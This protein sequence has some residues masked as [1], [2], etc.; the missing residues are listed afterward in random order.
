MPVPSAKSVGNVALGLSLLVFGIYFLNVL[1]G[2]P[3]GHKPWM[4]DV[5]EMLTLFVAVTLFVA[6]TLARERQAGNE[7]GH[8]ARQVAGIGYLRAIG[9][10]NGVARLE[11]CGK[12]G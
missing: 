8:F 2:G 7:A 6:G 10:E 1:L 5:T 11:A 4:S 12:S 3:L 9:L